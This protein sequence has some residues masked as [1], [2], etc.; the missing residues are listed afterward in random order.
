MFFSAVNSMNIHPH[1]FE[2]L[3]IIFT[4]EPTNKMKNILYDIGNKAEVQ[5]TNKSE[6]HDCKTLLRERFSAK[7]LYVKFPKVVLLK[8]VLLHISV[9]TDSGIFGGVLE[10]T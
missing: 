10:F 5:P 6:V 3:V 2:L 4:D 8:T 9:A 1:N 7:I